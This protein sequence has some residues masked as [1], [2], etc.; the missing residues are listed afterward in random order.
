M[1]GSDTENQ[2]TEQMFAAVGHAITQWSFVEKELSWLLG[3][4]LG[5]ATVDD[6]GRG[7]IA[8]N[9]LTAIFLFYSV[10][11]WR[12]RLQLIDAALE[13]HVMRS[14]VQDELRAEW[15]KLS[16]KSNAL[17]RKRNKLAHWFVLPAQRT[18]SGA[19]HE[20]IAPARL[21]PPYGSPNYY[22]ET[23]L[24]PPGKAL[25][26]KQVRELDCAFY[27]LE[28]KVRNFTRKLASVGELRDR[29][30][31]RALDRV[32]LDDRLDPPLARALRQYLA[33]QDE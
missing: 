18:G 24:N 4:C 17:A 22:R 5:G 14:T 9:S 11:N 8:P 27:Q 32:V 7:I 1:V 31:R 20:P 28:K 10:E 23:G 25:T 19:E 15:A 30:A 21:Y 16:D 3:V 2:L 26:E 12:S 13:V 29:D 33:S 6:D